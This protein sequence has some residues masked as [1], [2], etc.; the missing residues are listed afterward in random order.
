MNKSRVEESK[1]G[2]RWKK[3]QKIEKEEKER[4]RKKSERKGQSDSRKIVNVRGKKEQK[5]R[6]EK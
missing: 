2:E 4:K 6:G 3:E 5:K 1:E